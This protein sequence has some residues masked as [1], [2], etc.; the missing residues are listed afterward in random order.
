MDL[1]FLSTG[2]RAKLLNIMKSSLNL[3]ESSIQLM[4]TT[5]IWVKRVSRIII[6]KGPEPY[7]KIAYNWRVGLYTFLPFHYFFFFLVEIFQFHA[8]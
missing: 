4:E 2:Q 8:G 5:Q 3:I 6:I 1:P 7:F